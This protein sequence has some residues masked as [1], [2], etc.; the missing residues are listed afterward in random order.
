MAIG[1]IPF[2][3]A[4]TAR[5]GF[6]LIELAVVLA[7]IGII[8]AVSLSLLWNTESAD[9]A[10]VRSVQVQLES[11]AS[12]AA[13]LTGDP[14]NDT[15]NLITLATSIED[16]TDSAADV[17]LNCGAGAGACT[18]TFKGKGAGFLVGLNGVVQVTSLT[19]FSHFGLAGGQIIAL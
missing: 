3:L 6:T 17:T 5:P 7:I 16:Q 1:F 14:P 10:L 8:S 15:A 12:Q 11:G 13:M 19:G 4:L 18:L 9:A 2:K